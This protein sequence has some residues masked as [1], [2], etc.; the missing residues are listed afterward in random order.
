MLVDDLK[1]GLGQRSSL[2]M[3][4]SF[5]FSV[6][7]RSRELASKEPYSSL[8]SPYPTLRYGQ[9]GRECERGDCLFFLH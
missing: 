9:S 4:V 7:V 2:R 3:S 5:P 8:Y 6:H 1:R